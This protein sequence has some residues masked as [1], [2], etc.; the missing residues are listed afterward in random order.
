MIVHLEDVPPE[1]QPERSLVLRRAITAGAHSPAVSVTWVRID[2]RH[3]R[4]VNH[5]SDRV[6]YVLE[7]SGR[8]QVG[9]GAPAEAV[10]AGD[11]VFIARGTPY[12]LEGAMR[13]LV[14]NGPAFRAGA[15]IVLPASGDLTR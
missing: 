7:G 1:A 10:A 11:F 13:Y 3:D 8:F 6:Y 12:E 9:D 14:I 15:D 5:E 4:I 2:G